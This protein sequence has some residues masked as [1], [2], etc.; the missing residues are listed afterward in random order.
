ML[1]NLLFGQYRQRVLSLMLLNPQEFRKRIA[2]RD[3]FVLNVLAEPKL[4]VTGSPDDLG[5]LVADTEIAALRT[6]PRRNSTT[7]I[8]RRP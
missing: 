1:I 5:K 6:K 4:F 8:R 7:A 2:N 3:P